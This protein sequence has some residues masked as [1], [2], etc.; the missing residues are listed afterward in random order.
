MATIF[1]VGETGSTELWL[2]D[3]G[4]GTVQPLTSDGEGSVDAETLATVQAMRENGFSIAKSVDVAIA[5][6]TSE[7]VTAR[8]L[9]S[10]M[11]TSRMLTG[12]MLTGG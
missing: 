8:M 12:R 6:S 11:L 5:A 2:V 9:T 1:I 10:R 4:A 7:D 3:T